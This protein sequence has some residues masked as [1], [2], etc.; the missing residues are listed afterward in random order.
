MCKQNDER[1]DTLIADVMQAKIKIR[2][3]AAKR[4]EI[5]KAAEVESK[6]P[7]IESKPADIESK[8]AVEESKPAEAELKPAQV[9]AKPAEVEPKLQQAE[10]TL[11]AEATKS[12]KGA[13]KAEASFQSTKLPAPDTVEQL[14]IGEV[15]GKVEAQVTLAKEFVETETS[16]DFNFVKAASAESFSA[17]IGKALRE[18]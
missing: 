9:E 13:E 17:N 10:Q 4:P 14:R 12:V 2:I 1:V 5:P 11:Q 18:L 3:A 15:K 7:E 8:P 16:G 6:V